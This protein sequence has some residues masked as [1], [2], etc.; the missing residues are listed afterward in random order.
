[1]GAS[2]FSLVPIALEYL[3]EVTWPAS[4]EV[5]SVI[6]WTGGQLLGAIFIIIMSALKDGR[7]RDGPKMNMQRALIFEAIIACLV[8]PCPLLLGVR[9]LNL[10]GERRRRSM[11]DEREVA[12]V[13]DER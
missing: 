7:G 10:A 2:S 5:S 3:V 9:R 1:L 8:I 13:L 12:A 11:L 6:S 4:P